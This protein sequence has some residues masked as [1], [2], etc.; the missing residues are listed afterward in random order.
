VGINFADKIVKT[1]LLAVVEKYHVQIVEGSCTE[2]KTK[3]VNAPAGMMTWTPRDGAAGAENS[4]RGFV[5][6]AFRRIP[7]VGV[8]IASEAVR[9]PPVIRPVN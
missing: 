2:E 3:F 5:V 6:V 7:Y 1:I 4:Y 9:R 8:L